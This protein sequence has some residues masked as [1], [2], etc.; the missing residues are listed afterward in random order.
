VGIGR[1]PTHA[2][3]GQTDRPIHVPPI[4]QGLQPFWAQT[5]TSLY[6]DYGNSLVTGSV[7]LHVRATGN[8]YQGFFNP[9]NGV[10]F[11]QAFVTITPRPLG[12]L[13]LS[14]RVGAFV[15]NFG[16][17][18]EWGWGIFGPLIAVRGI[19]ETTIAEY[20]LTREL[21]G[22]AEYGVLAVPGVHEDFR[23]GDYTGWTEPGLSTFVQHA[24]AGG[25]YQNKYT[26]KLHYARASGTNERRRLGT[27][28]ADGRMEAW[29]AETRALLLP[30]GQLGVS[31][32]LWNFTRATAVHDGI[33]WGLDWTKGATDFMRDYL[34]ANANGTGRVAAVSA[35]YN[36]SLAQI[37]YHP[38][39]FDGNAPDIRVA[40]AGI[41]H[42]TLDTA[43]AQMKG[44]SG[45]QLG[46]HAFYQMLPWFGATLRSYAQNRASSLLG[47]RYEVYSIS[48][49][50]MFRSNW[51]SSD[52]IELIY[53]RRFY[54][55]AV[56]NNPAQPLDRDVIAL[57]AYLDF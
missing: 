44:S 14:A 55:S 6:M 43:D 5:G 45:Y 10:T 52:R 29:V 19:G 48:P 40:L 16:G 15:Q 25:I 7:K 54:S 18:G 53:S 46:A 28:F 33:W 20:D 57:G 35:E 1:K 9:P 41:A 12:K 2:T 3:P 37:A 31:G 49:G 8:E 36:V 38:R 50:L 42:W 26:L 34:G 23:R 11:G 24:H 17:P 51:Q 32:V 21:R 47:G 13:R 39:G 27:D 4:T 30:Y 22:Y 56:D